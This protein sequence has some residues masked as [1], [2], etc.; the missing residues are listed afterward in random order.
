[1]RGWAALSVLVAAGWPAADPAADG[2]RRAS[3]E[4]QLC[5]GV[6]RLAAHDTAAADT[7]YYKNLH[8][9]LGPYRMAYPRSRSNP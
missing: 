9:L 2:S 3:A 1:V 8:R 6:E 5:E 4:L 7:A